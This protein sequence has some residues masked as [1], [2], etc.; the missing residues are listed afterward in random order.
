MNKLLN[1]IVGG[2]NPYATNTITIGTG[3]TSIGYSIGFADGR[4]GN[5][6]GNIF[7]S[8]KPVDFVDTDMTGT[9]GTPL[10]ISFIVGY[11]YGVFFAFHP[12]PQ[13]YNGIDEGFAPIYLIR[14][15][16]Y[17][18]GARGIMTGSVSGISI[19][20]AEPFFTE[21]DIDKNIQIYFKTTPPSFEWEDIT[22]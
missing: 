21:Q 3:E 13:E 20:L 22:V 15:D 12:L 2:G 19:Q 5:T 4:N 17:K 16:T 14:L 8:I 7:G 6:L 18:G 1:T 9:A 11:S 10:E